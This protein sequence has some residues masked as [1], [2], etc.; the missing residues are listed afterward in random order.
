MIRKEVDCFQF[1]ELTV[2]LRGSHFNSSASVQVQLPNNSAYEIDL[3]LKKTNRS[4]LRDAL[5]ELAMSNKAQGSTTTMPQLEWLL[6]EIS[7]GAK[8]VHWNPK[9]ILKDLESYLCREPLVLKSRSIHTQ[10]ERGLVWI[11]CV[12]TDEKSDLSFSRVIA[13]VWKNLPEELQAAY[14]FDD[15]ERITLRYRAYSFDANAKNGVGKEKCYFVVLPQVLISIREEEKGDTTM[16]SKGFTEIARSFEQS[17]SLTSAKSWNSSSD[18]LAGIILKL[19]K[20]QDVFWIRLK[21]LCE[22][23]EKN[24]SSRPLHEDE[25]RTFTDLKNTFLWIKRRLGSIHTDLMQLEE[26]LLERDESTI[27]IEL[28]KRKFNF[29]QEMYKACR[30]L[31]KSVDDANLKADQELSRKLTDTYR[32]FGLMF[33]PITLSHTFL[34]EGIFKSVLMWAGGLWAMLYGARWGI[35]SGLLQSKKPA[36]SNFTIT[37]IERAEGE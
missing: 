18:L 33:L 20:H 16:L 15:L 9:Q 36:S 14:S 8:G 22:K 32:R 35:E 31:L 37:P 5:Q 12:T 27:S 24:R 4:K 2:T 7:F 23:L 6:D 29:R 25:K 13:T 21:N 30:E 26:A 1:G 3:P 11:D 34:H 17:E 28:I 19:E 10:K